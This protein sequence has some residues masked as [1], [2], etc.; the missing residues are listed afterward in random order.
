[1]CE[2]L[3][4]IFNIEENKAKKSIGRT[5]TPA[6]IYIDKFYP[7]ANIKTVAQRNTDNKK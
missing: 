2:V 1:M 3:A 4:S 5:F 6:S 7:S